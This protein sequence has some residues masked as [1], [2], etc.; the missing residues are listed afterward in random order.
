MNQDLEIKRIQLYEVDKA[1]GAAQILNR[2]GKDM[3]EK[4]GLHHWDNP[5]I[6]SCAIVGLCLLKNQVYLILDGKNPVA[7]FQIKKMEDVLFFEKLAVIPEESGKGYGSRCMKLIEGKAYKLGCSKVRL[8]V[9]DKSKHAIDFYLT[10][11]YIQVGK[12]GTRKYTD[13]IMEKTIRG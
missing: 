5:M 12:T 6:K 8:E 10:K 9:Y 2:C 7:T 3:A 13:L 1:L 11:G 4:Y